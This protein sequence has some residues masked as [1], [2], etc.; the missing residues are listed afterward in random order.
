MQ[1]LI[2]DDDNFAL[3]VLESTLVRMGYSVVIAHDGVEAMAVLGR[4][5]IR[6]MVTDWD[7]P[8]MDGVELCRSVR[9]EDLPG[10]VYVIMLTGRE[11]AKQRLEGLYAGADDFISKPLDPEELFVCLKTAERILALETREVA[12][13][14][15]AKL[16]ESRDTDTGA[17]VERVQ[18]Y[19]RILARNLSDEVK[20]RHGVDDAYVRLLY[21][22][23]PLHDLGKVGI[24]DVVLLKPGKLT[25]DEFAIMKTHT[26][27]GAQTLDSALQR[28]PNARFLQFAR[29]IA[30]SHHERFD[31]TGYPQ[32]LVG[33]Q[34]P[35]CARIV[36]LA[37]VYDA[38]TTRRIYKDAISHVEAK[39]I[40]LEGRNGHFDAEVVDA[41]TRSEAQIVAVRGAIKSEAVPAQLIEIPRRNTLAPSVAATTILV[42]E[43]DDVL[44]N[45]LVEL[46]ATTGETIIE[47]SN[48]VEAMKLVAQHDPRIVIADWMM[49]GCDGITLCQ[50]IRARSEHAPVHLIMITANSDKAKLLDAYQAGVDDFISKPFDI[51]ELLARTRAGLR[52]AK[53]HSELTTKAVGSQALT[54]QLAT[55]NSRLE[56][57][58]VTDEL[59]GLFNR[60]YAM[61]KLDEQW[62]F[63]ERY[64]NMLAVASVDI[65]HFKR[66]NDTYGHDAGDVVLSRV[67]AILREETRGTDTVCRVGGEEFL[68]IFPLLT[69]RE[70][71]VCV[72]RCRR[73]VAA[74]TLHV[75]DTA[76]SVTL[77]AGVAERS[78]DM[79]RMS[80]L[81]TVA[82]D[83]LYQ[84][85]REGRNMVR[86]GEFKLG[87]NAMNPVPLNIPEPTHVDMN[88]LLKRC[89]GDAK[90]AAAITKQ[91]CAQAPT[92]LARL[93][94]ALITTDAPALKRAAHSLKSMIAYIGHEP[95]TELARKIEH[96]AEEKRLAEVEP[97]LLSLQKSVE[98]AIAWIVE[99]GSKVSALSA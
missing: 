53:L 22:T 31:G 86:I 67:A 26:V 23:S 73:A 59:T 74:Q 79:S 14:A 50:Q 34:I 98:L 89:G 96:L 32:G 87:G 83:A 11:G 69:A 28:F 47:A 20:A 5:E 42:V 63:A 12:L 43:D 27:I 76:I 70:A 46:L 3:S 84:C 51:E 9:R 82:D 18:A 92:E 55:I 62:A 93:S 39:Q 88:A 71:Y 75:R 41:F 30:L 60:R 33:E 38:L 45:K 54:A 68:I 49:P 19:S 58:S 61:T 65:D 21:Q 52:S 4:G 72:E 64:G 29:S 94:Q 8:G 78:K 90:F 66:V 36:A 6:L 81:L 16:A 91:F 35:L 1:V 95:A 99:E 48:G 40:I 57:L 25:A 37:D 7:M 17:H 56:R 77:S 10:Y 97:L 24:P 2:V 85:K 80:D 13:F 15:L 44:R